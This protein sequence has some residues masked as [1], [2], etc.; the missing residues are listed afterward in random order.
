MVVHKEDL[1]RLQVFQ[2]TLSTLSMYPLRIYK[3]DCYETFV[4]ENSFGQ[5]LPKIHTILNL[6]KPYSEEKVLEAL[7]KKIKNNPQYVR[8]RLYHLL[9]RYGEDIRRSMW[10]TKPSNSLTFT[11]DIK[12]NKLLWLFLMLYDLF[13]KKFM[14]E[15][16]QEAYARDCLIGMRNIFINLS[17]DYTLSVG[18]LLTKEQLSDEI[19]KNLLLNYDFENI[20]I[21]ELT[22]ISRRRKVFNENMLMENSIYLQK[23]FQAFLKFQAKLP[24]LI[25]KDEIEKV[26]VFIYM[27]YK[28]NLQSVS[29]VTPKYLLSYKENT[30]SIRVHSE[31]NVDYSKEYKRYLRKFE[32]YRDFFLG[33][34]TSRIK[35]SFAKKYSG[36]RHEDSEFNPIKG[37]LERICSR[38]NADGGCYIQYNLLNEKIKLVAHYGENN[39]KEGI[40]SYIEKINKGDDKSILKRSRVMHIIRSYYSQDDKY[41][42]NDLILQEVEK[43]GILQPVKNHSIHSNIAIPVTFR[44]K[45]MG[46]LLIDSYRRYNFNKDDINLTL[47]IT[48]ALSV[49]IFDQIIEKNL[50]RI[51][52]NVPNTAELNDTQLIKKRFENLTLY[53][54]KIFFSYG[55]AIWEYNESYKN[56]TLKSTTLKDVEA[57]SI[58]IEEGNDDLILGLLIKDREYQHVEEFDIGSNKLQFKCC[59]PKKYDK[60]INAIKIYPIIQNKKLIG[61]FSIY[62]KQERDY[63]AIDVQSLKAVSEHLKVF[64]NIIS[65]FRAQKALIQS[66]ALHEIN[67]KLMMI[68][69]KTTQL[70]SLLKEAFSSLDEQ[71]RYYFGIKLQD[72]R[73]FSTDVKLSFDFISN[74][75]EVYVDK[76]FFDHEIEK[77]YIIAQ[78][79]NTDTVDIR[80][81]LS[82]AI[83]SIPKPY[84]YKKVEIKNNVNF[85]SLSIAPIVLNDICQNLIFNAIK[86]S[87]QNTKIKLYSKVKSNS[88]R[89]FIQNEGVDIPI[90]EE[91]DIFKYGY[92]CLGAKKYKEQI[93]EVSVNCKD[94]KKENAGIGLY[95]VESLLRRVLGGEINMHREENITNKS[96]LITFEIILPIGLLVKNKDKK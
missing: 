11:R 91:Y 73:S 94:G 66:N 7:K 58:V 85:H 31:S 76:N 4:D 42:M 23:S 16:F 17:D 52:Q 5:V 37:L 62:N 47:S 72:I 12:E 28:E 57:D 48:S 88:L 79:K 3:N 59:N 89:I 32:N 50:F 64:F 22:K 74:R 54:N 24:Q 75:S 83:K 18:R 6:A 1:F 30:F 65:T 15:K 27:V 26:S 96:T 71:T 70:E 67:S 78:N 55:L 21:F 46:V 87:F 84:M 41:N 90:K 56:F 39:Y 13:P 20:N 19:V 92:R 8:K 69:S 44:H 93:G 63:R 49:Q 86:Y 34:Y 51:I 81:V 45:L 35:T 14:L 80:K 29:I 25:S 9:E 43:D 68:Q 10:L 82:Q 60:R 33:E 38:L 40:E 77:K 2:Q 53:I 36:A 61:A 95:K